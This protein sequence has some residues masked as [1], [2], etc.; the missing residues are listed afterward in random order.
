[1]RA[2]FV[3]AVVLTATLLVGCRSVT[4]L[5]ARALE[6]NLPGQVVGDHPD[7]LT[8]VSCPSP[9]VKQQGVVTVCNAKL[10]E[11]PVQLTVTQLDDNGAVS[12]ALDKSLLDVVKS[13][14]VLAARFTKDLSID[15]TIEC[16]GAAV[17][18][19]VVGETLQCTARDPSLRSR[20]LVVTVLD[21]QGT[22][23]AALR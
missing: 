9:I 2:A 22:L 19:L 8:E 20:A 14:A 21:D 16:E 3:A 7:L 5:D 4:R 11:T 17:R 1:M 15:T 12:V 23:G 18:V 10:A 6:R 13:V